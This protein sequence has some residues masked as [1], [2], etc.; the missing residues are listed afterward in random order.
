MF[1]KDFGVRVLACD[2]AA[3]S[4]KRGVGRI[5]VVEDPWDVTGLEEVDGGV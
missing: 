2:M 4:R 3:K 5:G 1:N